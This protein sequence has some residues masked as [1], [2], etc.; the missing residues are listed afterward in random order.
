MP[1]KRC[2]PLHPQIS[3][4]NLPLSETEISGIHFQIE[5]VDVP[6]AK[7]RYERLIEHLGDWLLAE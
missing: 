1:K 6:D 2:E 7:E 3:A 4:G 5:F